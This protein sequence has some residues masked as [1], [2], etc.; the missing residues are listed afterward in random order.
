MLSYRPLRFL[1]VT[2]KHGGPKEHADKDASGGERETKGTGTRAMRPGQGWTSVHWRTL[3]GISC[4]RIRFCGG[5]ALS[6]VSTFS[7][8]VFT[9]AG[10]LFFRS[11]HSGLATNWRM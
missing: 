1:A 3:D 7:R 9:S 11:F 4:R 8:T 2:G 6:S 5:G 10:L